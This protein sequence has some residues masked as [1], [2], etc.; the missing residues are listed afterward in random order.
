MTRQPIRVDFHWKSILPGL[1]FNLELYRVKF[2]DGE[3]AECLIVDDFISK[4]EILK[5]LPPSEQDVFYCI[6]YAASKKEAILTA[7]DRWLGKMPS[8]KQKESALK[9]LGVDS[10]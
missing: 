7:M 5:R 8:Q 3:L 10:N 2:V 4:Q 1:F 6:L 9:M